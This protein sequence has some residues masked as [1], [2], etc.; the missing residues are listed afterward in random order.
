MPHLKHQLIDARDDYMAKAII[1][2]HNNNPDVVAVIGDGH[3][4]GITRK[5]K[6]AKIKP[7]VV[8]LRQ[9][10]ELAKRVP[11]KEEPVHKTLGKE[12]VHRIRFGYVYAGEWPL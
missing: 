2:I 8:R 1:A 12:R 6:E 10:R 11:K 5:L 9:V 7:E 3:I 4:M